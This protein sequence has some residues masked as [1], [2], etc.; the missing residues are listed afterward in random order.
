MA[1]EPAEYGVV[2]LYN[3]EKLAKKNILEL[4][5]SFVHSASHKLCVSYVC[6]LDMDKPEINTN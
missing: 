5:Y 4:I 2:E 6:K 3:L 1:D